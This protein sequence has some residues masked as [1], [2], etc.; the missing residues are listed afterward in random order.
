MQFSVQD[1]LWNNYLFSL[2]SFIAALNCV[3]I[4]FFS[5]L[6]RKHKQS[7]LWLSLMAL[8]FAIWT[9]CNGF[10][11]VCNIDADVNI[12]KS[13]QY[14]CMVGVAFSAPSYF[15]FSFSYM[16]PTK[17]KNKWHIFLFVV[18]LITSIMVLTPC[19]HDYFYSMSALPNYTPIREFKFTYTPYFYFHTVYSYSLVLAGSVMLFIRML[20]PHVRNKRACMIACIASIIFI[21]WNFFTSFIRTNIILGKYMSISSR[22]LVVNLFFL[23]MYLDEDESLVYSGQEGVLALLPFPVFILNELNRV[24][25]YNLQASLFLSP[26]MKEQE[27]ILFDD[28][29]SR[30]K[31]TKTQVEDESGDFTTRLQYGSST[32]FLHE[33]IISGKNTKSKGRLLMLVTQAE[34][35]TLFKDLEMKAF[36]DELSGCNNRHFLEVKKGDFDSEKSLPLSIVIFDIDRLKCANDN[37]GHDAGDKYI[38]MCADAVRSCIRSTD[39]L[40]RLGGDEFLAVLPNAS[41]DIAKDVKDRAMLEVKMRGENLPFETGI[42]VGTTTVHSV[43]IDF[44]AIM[45]IADEAM[46]EEKKS[47]LN[48]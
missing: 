11:Y 20:K 17:K 38:K 6:R 28:I 5:F 43:P 48:V 39:Y 23:T 12:M 46:Y 27:V 33:N 40:F 4:F 18:P 14:A 21:G 25:Y 47:I 24:L 44:S 37:F 35:S 2:F 7:F 9:S 31:V 16:M 36:Y 34:F 1:I 19:L 8:S 26:E 22:L 3:T 42:S 15:L 30:F 41:E 32:F 29:L 10:L 45:K 13:F